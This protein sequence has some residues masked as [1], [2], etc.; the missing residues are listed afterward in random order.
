MERQSLLKTA[1]ASREDQRVYR[2]QHS[3]SE[4]QKGSLRSVP[5]QG[6]ALWRKIHL[7]RW[8]P[9]SQQ[10]NFVLDIFLTSGFAC[11]RL[12]VSISDVVSLAGLR[13]L[14]GVAG[15][16]APPEISV[17]VISSGRLEPGL[18][19]CFSGLTSWKNVNREDAS[20]DEYSRIPPRFFKRARYFCN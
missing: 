20:S 8:V 19:S 3:A 17:S 11:G 2:D 5:F 18:R 14:D 10:Q 15:T 9:P 12:G 16:R 4:S 6:I 13:P 7:F 1:A